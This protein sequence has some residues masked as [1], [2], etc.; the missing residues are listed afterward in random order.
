MIPIK[1]DNPALDSGDEF[2]F[3]V[4]MY[5]IAN[6]FDLNSKLAFGLSKFESML[7][8]RKLKKYK[9]KKPIYVTGMARAGTTINLE[10]YS[11]HPDT[12]YHK[13]MHM[14]MPYLPN[15]WSNLANMT[16][17][18]T[19]PMQR[20]HKDGIIVTRESPEALEEILWK[21]FF[22]KYKYE[23][24]SNVF[25]G[26]IFNSEFVQFYRMHIRKLMANQNKSRYIAKNNYNVTRMSYILRFFP[27]A[28]F[29]LVLRNPVNHIASTIKQC[30]VFA[31]MEN[32]DPKLKRMTEIIGHHEFGPSKRYINI[33]GAEKV[34]EIRKLWD[35]ES[36]VLGWAKY[37]DSIYGFVR[38]QLENDPRIKRAVTVVRFEDLCNKSSE[39]IDRVLEHTELDKKKFEHIKQKY[40][41]ELRTPTYYDF[42][43]TEQELEDLISTT[44]ETAK[45]F[46]YEF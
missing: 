29:I 9:I 35:E 3:P 8:S 28:K 18:F 39:T 41:K 32:Q 5:Y 45:Y 14:P 24:R 21:K 4:P 42:K 33:D 46:G 27:D 25:D 38:K 37:W 20:L 23:N 16:N 30:G 7:M 2:T 31:Q 15:F 11:K 34:R 44:K 36:N 26:G 40:M 13:Y 6:F 43:F 10:M 1:L 19:D 12:A 22:T 17:I